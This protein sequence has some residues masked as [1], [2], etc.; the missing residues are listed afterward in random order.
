[1]AAVESRERG[2]YGCGG[3][4]RERI[5]CGADGIEI[6][7]LGEL[8]GGLRVEKTHRREEL[9]TLLE[10]Q[11]GLCAYTAGRKRQTR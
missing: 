11:L 5:D 6:S 3:A 1:M 8:G 9:L 7:G 2:G 10:V 4:H